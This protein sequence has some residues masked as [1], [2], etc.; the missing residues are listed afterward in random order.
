LATPNTVEE[1]IYSIVHAQK[2]CSYYELQDRAYSMGIQSGVFPAKEALRKQGR[3]G[4][5]TQTIPS[6]TPTDVSFVYCVDCLN[7]SPEEIRP[8]YEEKKQLLTCHYNH[9]KEFAA[10]AEQLVKNACQKLQY[11]KLE[12]NKKTDN[13][14]GILDLEIDV[15]GKPPNRT[16]YQA[17]S[18]KNRREPIGIEDMN[19]IINTASFASQAW[20]K[21]IRPA[22][23]ATY[24]N[25]SKLHQ[26]KSMGLAMTVWGKQIIPE[27][28]REEYETRLI[29]GLA[30]QVQITDNPPSEMT[31][32][33]SEFVLG[34]PYPQNNHPT[35][36]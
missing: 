15:F 13:G 28:F 32:N 21:D 6:T 30:L 22:L 36:A 24:A 10:H 2:T 35:D 33:L 5:I 7:R 20:G 27:R 17:I 4:N 14:I 11:T 12:T 23:V 8:V 9:R 1:A 31:R 25:P 19:D 18:V 34:Y 3:L 16:Y 29:P 26:A